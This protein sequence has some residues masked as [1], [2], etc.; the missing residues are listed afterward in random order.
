MALSSFRMRV[1]IPAAYL[2]AA[3]L[4]VVALGEGRQQFQDDHAQMM[5]MAGHLAQMPGMGG[6]DDVTQQL[7]CQQ[8]CMFAAAAFPAP[9]RV[10]ETVARSS[11]GEVGIV[12]LPTSLA[13]PPPGRPPK[14]AVI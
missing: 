7:L 5:A 4:P 3:I 1:L 8:H 9:D 6:A 12:M 10:P 13:I 14:I 2:V 11:D